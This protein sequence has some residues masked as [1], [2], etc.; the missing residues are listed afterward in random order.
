MNTQTEPKEMIS[1]PTIENYEL[2][3]KNRTKADEEN[4]NHCPCCG[5]AI[6][7]PK[8]FVNSIYGGM[9]YPKNDK[10]QYSD[11]WV[12]G[13]GSE[14]RKNLPKDYVMTIEEL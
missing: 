1:I 13:I 7:N 5:K 6:R 4:L 11:S 3:E 10:T 8:F 2:F 9:M 14:C 12:M